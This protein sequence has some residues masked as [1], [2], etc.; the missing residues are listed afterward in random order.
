M[1]R[2]LLKS[3]NFEIGRMLSRDAIL[4]TVMSNIK[5]DYEF[6]H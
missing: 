3:N 6:L 4:Y 5:T 2:K 1:H